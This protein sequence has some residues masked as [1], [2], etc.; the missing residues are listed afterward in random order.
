MLPA[1]KL[2]YQVLKE[3]F[4]NTERTFLLNS[5]NIMKEDT[6]KKKRKKVDFSKYSGIKAEFIDDFDKTLSDYYD[7]IFNIFFE[8]TDEDLFLSFWKDK[9]QKSMHYKYE[10]YRLMGAQELIDGCNKPFG[11]YFIMYKFQIVP[12]KSTNEIPYI[13]SV[14]N[15][16][17]LTMEEIKSRFNYISA[18]DLKNTFNEMIEAVKK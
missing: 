11:K 3:K 2:K 16:Y 6:F 9:D 14:K 5:Y 18:V 17:F 8:K 1:Q 4:L 13:N 10:F 12:K 15:Y 7:K